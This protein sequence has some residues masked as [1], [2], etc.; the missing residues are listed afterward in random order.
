MQIAFTDDRAECV[1]IP[2]PGGESLALIEDN[3]RDAIGLP[4]VTA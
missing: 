2:S 1:L 4:V 3:L